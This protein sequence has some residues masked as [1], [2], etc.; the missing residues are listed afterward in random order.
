MGG[1]SENK[2]ER[3]EAGNRAECNG[4]GRIFLTSDNGPYQ[5][6]VR[7]YSRVLLPPCA[8]IAR[9]SVLWFVCALRVYPYTACGS[10]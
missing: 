10:R 4:G 5:E 8:T 9:Q 7:E 6:E 3:W 2:S 1:V